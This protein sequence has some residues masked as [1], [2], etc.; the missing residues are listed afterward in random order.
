MKQEESKSQ[1]ASLVAQLT[2]EEKAGL[3]S[4]FDN[5]YTKPVERLGIPSFRMSDGPHGLRIQEGE[6]NSLDESDSAPAVC[7]PAACAAAASFDRDL[8]AKMGEELGRECQAVGINV[9]LGP[10]LNMKRIPLSGR[11]FEY[12]S[13]DPLLSGE[14]GAAFVRGLQSQGVGAC[15]KHFFANNQEYRRMDSS[16]EMDERTMREIYLAAFET[17]VKKAR[18]WAV[19][20]SYNRI[21]GIYATANKKYLDGVLRGEWGFEGAVIS[22]WG[23]VHDRTAAIAAGCDL[24]MP[25]ENT[26]SEIVQTVKEGRI[27]EKEL[28][29]CCERVISLAFQAK[30]QR[31]DGI[32]FDYDGGHALAGEIAAQSIVLLKNETSLLPLNKT[33]KAAFIGG[34]ATTPR[35][36]GGGS[37]HINSF[38]APGALEAARN[39]GLPVEFAQGYND[40]NGVV[41]DAQI[42]EAAALAKA[43]KVA[44]VFAGLP[45]SME[46]EGVDRRNLQMPEGH[47]RLI[48]AV[49]AVQPNTVVVLH[50]GGPVEMP[51]A[52][53]VPAIVEAFLGGQAAGEA[54]VDILYGDVN[55]SGHLAESF[56]QKLSDSPAYLFYPGEDGKVCY[57]E[58]FFTGYR[59]YESKTMK[60][61]FPFGHGLS[62]TSFKFD[63]LSLDKA[64]MN[65]DETLAV[66]VTV[67]NTGGRA[68]KAV[69]QLYIAP[70]KGEI[71]RPVR[72]LK[73]FTKVDLQPG[74]SKT[75]SFTLEKRGFAF[76]NET[77]HDWSVESGVYT[78]QIGED[79]H[80]IL[81]EASVEVATKNPLLLQEYSE[82]TPIKAFMKHP[83]GKQFVESNLGHMLSGMA[84]AGYFPKEILS[85]IHYQ[86]GGS[87]S[88]ETL[89]QIVS[90]T[91]RTPGSGIDSLFNQSITVMLNFVP[92]EVKVA[93]KNLLKKI[94]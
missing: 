52:D 22:D 13:E 61:L 30:E 29:A 38:K 51:W 84:A 42:E 27:S 89:N 17:V 24:T 48:Q 49:R 12:F 72:E 56:P 36:Q 73:E 2:L 59:Y 53:S 67:S 54:I 88:M 3:C 77:V 14:L 94:Q 43:S 20:A 35:Y 79:A 93:F 39:A 78:V 44:V 9:L 80:T 6:I 70:P 19:M 85:A 15:V 41:S 23:A 81:L 57:S 76:W 21:D 31:K 65:D 83:L 1:H 47:N 40:K 55:P 71:I 5:W 58:R 86:P 46:S 90:R 50:N 25:A 66:S 11:N 64:K 68:G 82:T 16:S 74:E 28:D 63:T 69:V 7:F 37:S 91:G 4:G 75:V 87:I 10:G 18:P 34:F 32:R 33:D 8:I 26:D 60:P 62:Y 45:D 92:E